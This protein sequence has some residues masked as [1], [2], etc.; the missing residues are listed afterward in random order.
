MAQFI[1]IGETLIN[2]QWVRAVEHAGDGRLNVY[3][4]EDRASGLVMRFSG[5]EAAEAWALLCEPGRV[6]LLNDPP[7]PTG[8]DRDTGSA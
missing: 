7:G 8:P 1:R 5:A 2:L 3:I 4:S 6:N